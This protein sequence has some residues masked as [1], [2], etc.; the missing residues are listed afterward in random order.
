MGFGGGLVNRRRFLSGFGVL[1]GPWVGGL[2]FAAAEGPGGPGQVGK[3][4]TSWNT[5][6]MLAISTRFPDL[7][8][9]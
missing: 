6:F 2:G 7:E 8:S 5:L 4:S 1:A 9:F 3:L